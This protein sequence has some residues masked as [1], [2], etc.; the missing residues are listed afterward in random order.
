MP[1]ELRSRPKIPRTPAEGEGRGPRG[2]DR[3]QDLPQHHQNVA[4]R[5]K[6]AII[7]DEKELKEHGEAF[8]SAEK[9]AR[10]PPELKRQRERMRLERLQNEQ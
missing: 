1:S 5:V 4:V 10:T 8:I 2:D 3:Q 6:G 9:I 7:T